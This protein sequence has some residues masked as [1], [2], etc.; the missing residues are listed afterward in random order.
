MPWI[1]WGSRGWGSR[2]PGP[3]GPPLATGLPTTFLDRSVD[4]LQHK[5]T[6]THKYVTHKYVTAQLADR[7]TRMV[8]T[9]VN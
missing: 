4:S 7:R 6:H 1:A 2:G 9:R 3:P 8:A 5:Y